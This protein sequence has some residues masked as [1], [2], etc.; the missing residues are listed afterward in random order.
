MLAVADFRANGAQSMPAAG[1]LPQQADVDP[2]LEG[3][4]ELDSVELKTAGSSWKYQV[5]TILENPTVR[6]LFGSAID[7]RYFTVLFCP[8]AVEVGINGTVNNNVKGTCSA[9]NGKLTVSLYNETSQT[10]DYSLAGERLYLS[11]ARQGCQFSLIFKL[12]K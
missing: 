6:N 5:K 7:E 11:Y 12:Y 8:N 9:A 2:R 4:W 3:V 10:F 1:E